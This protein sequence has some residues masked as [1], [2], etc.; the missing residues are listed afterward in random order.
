MLQIVSFRED[1]HK[2][3]TLSTQ[4][5]GEPADISITTNGAQYENFQRQVRKQQRNYHL[6]EEA[7]RHPANRVTACIHHSDPRIAKEAHG[8]ETVQR[9]PETGTACVITQPSGWN[10]A[11]RPILHPYAASSVHR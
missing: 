8:P 10:L 7:H 6:R 4:E 2:F 9:S 5:S 3:I 11:S 1:R